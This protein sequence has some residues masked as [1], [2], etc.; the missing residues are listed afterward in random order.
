MARKRKRVVIDRSNLVYDPFLFDNKPPHNSS[1]S[2]ACTDADVPSRS[3]KRKNADSLKA[4]A[5]QPTHVK[6]DTGK[7]ATEK[8][9]DA[10]EHQLEDS[11]EPQINNDDISSVSNSRGSAD[12]MQ[13]DVIETSASN[14]SSTSP[15]SSN[16]DIKTDNS[17]CNKTNYSNVSNTTGSEING[18]HEANDTPLP[19]KT[20]SKSHRSP[21][22]ESS[23]R[24]ATPDLRNP[25]GDEV[26]N[27]HSANRDK[28]LNHTET[29]RFKPEQRVVPQ[30]ECSRRDGIPGGSQATEN[31][32]GEQRSELHKDPESIT[33]LSG[34]AN[35]QKDSNIPNADPSQWRIQMTATPNSSEYVD[36]YSG[37][38]IELLSS[39]D[40]AGEE[41]TQPS[42]Q[43]DGG[44]S[45]SSES[46][47]KFINAT[48]QSDASKDGSTKTMMNNPII[49]PDSLSSNQNGASNQ[50]KTSNMAMPPLE[51]NTQPIL[52]HVA[53]GSK[54]QNQRERFDAK[55]PVKT[56]KNFSNDRYPRYEI[57]EPI[58]NNFSNLPHIPN[59]SNMPNMQ[60]M[61]S[62]PNMPNIPG[63]QHISNMPN[64]SCMPNG[65][66]SNMANPS[67]MISF[68]GVPPV[69]LSSMNFKPG[70]VQ[71]NGY[72]SS[73]DSQHGVNTQGLQNT[74]IPCNLNYP[75]MQGTPVNSQM[76][77]KKFS[78]EDAR[79]ICEMYNVIG[80]YMQMQ[81]DNTE[82]PYYIEY[83]TA[84]LQSFRA[85][86]HMRNL[87][88]MNAYADSSG[89]LNMQNIEKANNR[90]AF[91]APPDTQ[92]GRI[93]FN[94]PNIPNSSPPG[95]NTL[96]S[97]QSVSA[98][99]NSNNV[100]NTERTVLGSKDTRSNND[101]PIPTPRAI[102]ANLRNSIQ[103]HGT[104]EAH[105]RQVDNENS[106]I[107]SKRPDSVVAATEAASQKAIQAVDHKKPPSTSVN[108]PKSKPTNKR[109]ALTATDG[110]K[111]PEEQYTQMMSS[112]DSNTQSSHNTPQ[113][114]AAEKSS[115]SVPTKSLSSKMYTLRINCIIPEM[116]GKSNLT[117][118]GID[119]FYALENQYGKQAVVIHREREIKRFLSPARLDPDSEAIDLTI[120]TREQYYA[121]QLGELSYDE[122]DSSSSA[123]AAL[124]APQKQS[125]EEDD[126]T[127]SIVLDGPLGSVKVRVRPQTKMEKLLEYYCAQKTVPVGKK[128]RVCFDAEKIALNKT[129]ADLDIEEDDMIDI[130]YD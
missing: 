57:N 87:N 18:Q 65:Y 86:K 102:R 46:N 79:D 38:V 77:L 121:L 5:I 120:C 3:G 91:S 78:K 28:C 74:I 110:D 109:T 127:F 126:N 81:Q 95:V 4:A 43:P 67:N 114:G 124:K 62:M 113:D 98:N 129:I 123:D 31:N 85:A 49:G 33:R 10:A 7:N 125:T 116:K 16:T 23:R 52:S 32:V 64:I 76:L 30:S 15:N 90:C 53:Q 88:G 112:T 66:M 48:V 22:S 80:L 44:H 94:S 61:P 12:C 20:S 103:Q 51:Q 99:N 24:S 29:Q 36:I 6:Q 69:Q 2:D 106:G 17:H 1:D 96:L 72:N 119:P 70:M 108:V 45:K 75:Y 71:N 60:N 68:S 97:T 11:K 107:S 93:G 13:T 9:P 100:N 37:E 84:M 40:E 59:M 101:A 111:A 122:L 104:I 89:S 118:R 128:F 42:T 25:S 56:A 58:A 14:Q 73:T 26:T 34:T 19:T 105:K 41:S 55:K 83:I 50:N 47:S 92:D 54:L 39:E 8:I 115:K 21:E 117:W 35:S 27:T 130:M 82:N 63:L